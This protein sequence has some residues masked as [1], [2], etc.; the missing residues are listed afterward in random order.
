VVKDEL[1]PH[2]ARSEHNPKGLPEV[3]VTEARVIEFGPTPFPAYKGASAGVRSSRD[4]C[5][6]SFLPHALAAGERWATRSKPGYGGAV[7]E[8]ERVRSGQ[9]ASSESRPEDA[10][11]WLEDRCFVPL[12]F[13]A[14]N[15][16]WRLA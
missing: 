12:P 8:R 10:D 14:T 9:P 11:W 1:R 6:K 16:S 3:T 4:V 7:L 15:E 5:V 13:T 2:P